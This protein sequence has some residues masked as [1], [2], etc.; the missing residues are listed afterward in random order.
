M[1]SLE[2]TKDILKYH[3]YLDEAREKYTKEWGKMWDDSVF[4]LL[5]KHGFRPKKTE[6]YARYLKSRLKQKGLFLHVIPKETI[7]KDTFTITYTLL[8]ITKKEYEILQNVKPQGNVFKLNG[9][10]KNEG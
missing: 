1:I 6:T 7:T 9:G 3:D 8:L 4:E 5:K 2:V 10:L